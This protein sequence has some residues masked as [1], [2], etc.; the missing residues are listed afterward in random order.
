MDPIAIPLQLVHTAVLR[1]LGHCFIWLAV[2]CRIWCVDALEG[3]QSR[4]DKKMRS[5]KIGLHLVAGLEC[6][7]VMHKNLVTSWPTLFFSR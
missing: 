2:Y 6:Q 4:Q 1:D 7:V 5:L 3:I